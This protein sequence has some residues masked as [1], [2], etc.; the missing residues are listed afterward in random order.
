[1]TNIDDEGGEA[2]D[3]FDGRLAGIVR[4]IDTYGDESPERQPHRRRVIRDLLAGLMDKAVDL[5]QAQYDRLDEITS[6]EHPP[7]R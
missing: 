1:M 4:L 6:D 5:V 3:T 7:T 2:P